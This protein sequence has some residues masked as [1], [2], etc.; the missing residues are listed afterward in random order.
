MSFCNKDPADDRAGENGCCYE[1]E[2]RCVACPRDW[3]GTRNCANGRC[4]LVPIPVAFVPWL[5][6][7]WVPARRCR[8]RH[9]SPVDCLFSPKRILPSLHLLHKRYLRAIR[10]GCARGSNVGTSSISS[11]WIISAIW[12]RSSAPAPPDAGSG[13]GA[14]ECRLSQNA[15]M[16][17]TF[18]KPRKPVGPVVIEPP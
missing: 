6:S 16:I 8:L 13:S 2:S 10:L 3:R 12:R 15:D 11:T 4:P 5:V 9:D 17:A 14:T 7:G 18:S 1:R